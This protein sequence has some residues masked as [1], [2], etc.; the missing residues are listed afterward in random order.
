MTH[1]LYVDDEPYLLEIFREFLEMKGDMDVE[2]AGSVPE[3]LDLLKDHHVDVIVSDYQMPGIDGIEF[4]RMIRERDASLPFILFT[5]KSREDVVIRAL[6]SGADYYLQKGGDASAQFAEMRNL[7]LH[8]VGRRLAEAAQRESELRY[9]HVVED[10]TELIRRFLPDGTTVFANGAFC[11]YYGVDEQEVIGST[12]PPFLLRGEEERIARHLASLSPEEPVKPITT[13]LILSDGRIR[14]HHQYDRALFDQNG[15]VTEYQSVGRDV[16]DMTISEANLALKNNVF[17][18]LASGEDILSDGPAKWALSE[19]LSGIAWALHLDQ[20]TIQTVGPGPEGGPSIAAPLIAWRR[21]AALSGVE[22]TPI[23]DLRY[24]PC[25]RRWLEIL[26]RG[27]PVEGD[28]QD[29]SEEE[30]AWAASPEMETFVAFPVFFRGTFW[31]FIAAFGKDGGRSW[32]EE[33]RLAFGNAS[34]LIRYAIEWYRKGWDLAESE[35]KFKAIAD[36]AQDAIVLID[37]DDRVAYWNNAARQMFGYSNEDF[38]SRTLHECITGKS[39]DHTYYREQFA[40][41]KRTGRT[42][43]SGKVLE[44]TARR[45]DGTRFAMELSSSSINLKGEWHLLAICRDI[46]ERKLMEDRLRENEEKFRTIAE[47]AQDAIVLVDG[48]DRVRF[49]N[50]AAEEMFGYPADEILDRSIYQCLKREGTPPHYTAALEEFRETGDGFLDQKI[51]EITLKCRDGRSLPVEVSV[52]PV[53]IDGE[54]LGV[55][56]IRDLSGRRAAEAALRES[57]E[58]YRTIFETTLDGMAVIDAETLEVLMANRAFL[59]ILGYG[60]SDPDAAPV[61]I[62]DLIHPAWKDWVTSLINGDLLGGEQIDELPLVLQDGSQRWIRVLGRMTLFGGRPAGLISCIDIT[63]KRRVEVMLRRRNELEALIRAISTRFLTL[64]R[65]DLDREFRAVLGEVG[66]ALEA[67]SATI[68]LFNDEH[69]RVDSCYWWSANGLDSRPQEL[70][71]STTHRFSWWMDRLRDLKPIHIPSVDAMPEESATEKE[72]FQMFGVGSILAF[73]IA[74][75]AGLFGHISFQTVG[76]ECSWSEEDIAILSMLGDIVADVHARTRAE[77]RLRESEKKFR[78]FVEG[79]ND[80]F[81]RMTIGPSGP[82]LEYISPSFEQMSGYSRECMF[83]HR[84]MG[85]RFLHPDDRARFLQWQ[86]SSY[87]SFY[88]PE[89]FRWMNRDGRY[90]WTENCMIPVFDEEGAVVAIE[91]VIHDIDHIKRTEEAFKQTNKKLALLGSITRHDILNQL[92]AAFGYLDLIRDRI[93][94]PLVTKFFER[95]E[96]ALRQIQ[97]QIEFTKSYQELG[98]RMPEWQKVTEVIARVSRPFIEEGIRVMADIDGLEVYADPML[99]KVFYNLLDNSLRHGGAVSRVTVS[100]MRVENVTQIIWQD[101][102]VGVPEEEKE[103]IFDRG[104]GKNTGFGLFLVREVLSITDMSINECGIPGKG[105][106]FVITVPPGMFRVR[107][108]AWIAPDPINIRITAPGEGD[109]PKNQ[110]YDTIPDGHTDRGA[111]SPTSIDQR[112]RSQ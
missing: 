30:R 106:K 66:G 35:A 99:E 111:C 48:H 107:G 17:G 4:L 33:E 22:V 59:N 65:A 53:R 55:G 50:R 31:G 87:K 98:V 36:L 21:D 43:L 109:T 2:V 64:E 6:N 68:L 41:L 63:E 52:S 70:E 100:S 93:D 49:W 5:G 69:A 58:S 89:T 72:F 18:I 11:R 110:P 8:A 40:E 34:D 44:L 46:S 86:R 79:S 42:F 67:D 51:F 61:R 102:G 54:W 16:T 108:E 78:S 27:D 28:L 25:P 23:P 91:I 104:V 81:M 20:V 56:I 71:N 101:D 112:R 47:L 37:S 95:Q 84:D 94:D 3:A 88:R 96:G 1:V 80:V 76:R 15:A 7:I 9:R 73:P 105:A 85:F 75:K 13:R 26:E 19:A 92:T 32:A 82:V 14:W 77:Q 97:S 39:F 24:R 29:F 62:F 83:T 12:A 45:K 57:E 38:A 74:S 103:R 60:S 90:I 10:Q